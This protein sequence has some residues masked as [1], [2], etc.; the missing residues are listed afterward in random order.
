MPDRDRMIC[1]FC[2]REFPGYPPQTCGGSFLDRDHPSAVRPVF[3]PAGAD[4]NKITADARARY[5]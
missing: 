2:R 3:V 4:A 1:P 5:S